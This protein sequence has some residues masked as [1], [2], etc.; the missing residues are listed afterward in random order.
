MYMALCVDWDVMRQFKQRKYICISLISAD[1]V[2]NNK[3]N[4][5]ANAINGE[6]EESEGQGTASDEVEEGNVLS[7]SLCLSLSISLSLSPSLP[8]H[9]INGEIEELRNERVWGQ[10]QM[11]W[12]VLY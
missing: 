11:K 2:I 8:P 5:M 1:P 12:K 7:I 10:L 3:G 6:V 9:T 4:T